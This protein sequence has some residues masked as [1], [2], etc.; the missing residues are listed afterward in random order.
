MQLGE[1]QSQI[2][3]FNARKVQVVALSVDEPEDSSAMIRRMNLAFPIASDQ[4]QQVMR[5][6][7]VQNP[8]TQELALHAVYIVD[9]DRNIFY[10]KVARRR[11]LSQELL[12]AIDYHKGTYPG[13]DERLARGDIPVAFPQNYFQALLEISRSATL[14]NQVAPEKLIRAPQ[15]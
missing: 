13:G 10:R 12:D 9:E 5:A 11:P 3:R 14:P 1:L 7:G 2:S 8:D 6:Y 15:G 4:F